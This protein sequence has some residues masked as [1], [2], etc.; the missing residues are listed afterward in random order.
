MFRST[1]GPT[2]AERS[3]CLCRFEVP[4]SDSGSRTTVA[5]RRADR[6]TRGHFSADDRTI[7]ERAVGPA[8]FSFW[9]A[10]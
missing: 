8:N 1:E 6:N 7:G 3:T 4:H 10:S 5:A 2:G 9:A